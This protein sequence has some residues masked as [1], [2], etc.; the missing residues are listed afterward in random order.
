MKEY[1]IIEIEYKYIKNDYGFA[2]GVMNAEAQNGWEVVSTLLDTVKNIRG[3]VLVITFC[4]ER[5][6]K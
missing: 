1:K 3:V 2:E 4:R 5:D 6:V